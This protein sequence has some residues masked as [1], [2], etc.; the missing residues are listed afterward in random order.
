MTPPRLFAL[1]A[2]VALALSSLS[3][4]AWAH[5]GHDS[6]DGAGTAASTG[7]LSPGQQETERASQGAAGSWGARRQKLP[8]TT[9]LVAAALAL[10]GAIP[11]RRRALALV[12]VL[13]LTAVSFEGLLH[14]VLHLHHVRHADSLA[15]GASPAQQTATA[16]DPERPGPA[17]DALLVEVA[18]RYDT[19]AIGVVVAANRGRAPPVV[20]A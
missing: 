7:I 10:L 12:L 16:L 17:P 19:P 11:Y 9:A 13:L 2:C 18:E 1:L 15:I 6:T 20:S 14:A 4:P 3:G 5:P 8:A